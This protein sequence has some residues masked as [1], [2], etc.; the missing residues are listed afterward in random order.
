MT[1]YSVEEGY[2]N[3]LGLKIYYKFFRASDERA[4][5]MTMH[6]GPGMSHDYMLPLS[7]LAQNGVSVLFYDQFGCGRSDEPDA[8]SKYTISYGVEEAEEL[9]KQIFA[10]RKIFL[11]G[12]S[13]GGALALAYAVK[14]QSNLR[15]LI[16]SGGLPSVQFTVSEM[17]RLIDELDPWARDAIRKYG[18]MGEFSNED[19]KRASELFYKKHFLRLNEYPA[20]VLKSLEYAEKRNVYRIMNGPDEFTITG[21]IKDWDITQQLAL[22]NIPTLI[23]AGEFDEV[24]PNVASAIHD[25]IHGSEMVIFKG[26]SHLTMWEDREKYNELLRKFI[27]HTV[28]SGKA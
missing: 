28:E 7:D 14:Y 3:V 9:R 23:T 2:R 24:T 18:E 16:I 11:M 4:T 19:Y 17:F 21:T 1:E 13:Y 15:G 8:E 5:V 20:E 6:G 25:N 26:C 12:S 22:I 10:D 27:N